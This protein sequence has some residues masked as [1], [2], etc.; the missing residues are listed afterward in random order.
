VSVQNVGS[1]PANIS[2]TCYDSAGQ[3]YY[4]G[5]T[6]YSVPSKA[7]T[8]FYMSAANSP[9]GSAVVSANQPI[10]SLIYE[11][12]TPYKLCT[13]ADLSGTTTAYAPELYGNYSQGGQTWNSGLHIQ[14]VGDVN[15]TVTVTYYK[16]DGQYA[17]QWSNQ[18]GPKLTWILN[19]ASGN[20]PTNNFS[21][22]AVIQATQPIAAVVNTAHTGSGD[23]KASYTASNR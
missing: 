17:G 3:T 20:M 13:N 11:G 15:A 12:G 10:A 16:E 7:T 19:A 21:G 8:T 14:N 2:I 9:L 18:V 23:T 1:Q 22:S 5:S 6:R 4:C